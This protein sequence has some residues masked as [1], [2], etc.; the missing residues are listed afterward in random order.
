[1]TK[2]LCSVILSII[3]LSN[4]LI[5]SEIINSKSSYTNTTSYE[6]SD[7][8]DYAE[9]VHMYICIQALLLLKDKFPQYNYTEF[10]RHTGTMNDFGDRQWQTG[11]I[12]T[13]AYREDKEDVV[14]D[15]RG[16]FGFFASNSHFW[17]ADNRTGGDHTFTNLNILGINYNYPN[18]YSKAKR[19]EDGNWQ[20]WSGSGYGG[21]RYI[22]Y[23]AGNGKFYRFSYHTKGL[24][25]FYKTNRIWLESIINTL[26]ETELVRNEI[27]I[28]EIVK[29]RIVWE[30]LG[31]IAHLN[32]D[33]SVSAHTKNDVHVRIWDGGDCYHNYIDDGAYLNYNWHTAKQSGGFFNPYENNDDPLRYLLY[34]SA[35]LADHF[36]SGPVC[37]EIPQQ[38]SGNNSLPGGS[39]QMIEN[40]YSRLGPSPQNISDV[41]A[42][43]DYC[44]NHA[45]RSTS[46]LF[47]WF[48]VE[49]GIFNPDPLA[50]PVINSFSKNL[51]DNYVYKEETL[52]LT[53]NASGS[54]LS[55]EWF[56]SVCD[57]NSAC[58]EPI[59]GLTFT[60]D[61]NRL[62]IRNINFK[63]KYTCSYYDSL[64]YPNEE[65]NLS[66]GP[67]NFLIGVKVMNRH[68]Q[69][70]KFFNF[71]THSYF[72][73]LEI[74]RPPEPPV[75][76]CPWL[77]VSDGYQLKYRNSLLKNSQHTKN[78]GMDI[79]DNYVIE[80]EPYINLN[81]KSVT[82]GIKEISDDENLTDQIRARII[83]H[84]ENS[85]IGVTENGDV[86]LYYPDE[87]ISPSLALLSGRNVSK[88][89]VYDSL[90]GIKVKGKESDKLYL[91]FPVN[92]G[93]RHLSGNFPDSIALILDPNS[94]EDNS[95]NP[96]I[97]NVTG[98]ITAKDIEGNENAV[99]S[100]FGMRQ[101]R[102]DLFIPV[103]GNKKVKS[104]E[105]YW[106][107]DFEYSYIG[108]LPVYYGGFT[109][110]N[111]DL[112]SAAD[113]RFGDVKE[114]LL[115]S[116]KNY[117]NADSSTFL[118]M[119]FKPS[120]DKP[121]AGYIRSY[122]FSI[123]GRS[124]KS[125]TFSENK[126]D[127]TGTRSYGVFR[128]RLSEIFPNPFNPETNLEFEISDPGFV[129]LK[130]YDLLGKE[131]ATIVNE[132]L[133]PGN[134]R[135]KF[136]GSSLR[137]GVYF[138]KLTTG[139]YSETKKML[140]IK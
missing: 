37:T 12:T 131:A 137:S 33:L 100:D 126:T 5:C 2:L 43:A 18:A 26:G 119:N 109:E 77:L 19:Y 55:Y 86:I 74:L 128:N 3:I 134:Y 93:R 46:A 105:I 111:L 7:S 36:P 92:S 89:T 61:G 51:P 73:P 22:E 28:S 132:T 68:G 106:D 21:K 110:R 76:G 29:D 14:F 71:N 114:L 79:T 125:N 108:V 69:Q 65:N 117:Y 4:S 130:V 67:L 57:S 83:D 97:K 66:E 9:N 17:N 32:Q 112:T 30:V 82:L 127:Q 133:K 38:H 81:E 78:Y 102:S 27:R 135:I 80:Q 129:T 122:V 23:N 96:V 54:D 13:G 107:R 42:E 90:Y 104:A 31:R 99:P 1:M 98:V 70:K 94:P 35:Q 120:G 52:A 140:L 44:F 101:L 20:E 16:P 53:C 11:L 48:G 8:G 59:P 115:N 75:S 95:G 113:Y 40:Y 138:M 118:I 91:E 41:G 56:F 62:F 121:Q 6:V 124:I 10:D 87:I 45:I 49:T 72:S 136:N 139:S 64:C 15:I 116:D 39:N 84:P 34:T 88:E 24:A 47:Y 85:K 103:F 63:N 60:A 123:T 50:L 58:T 25:E